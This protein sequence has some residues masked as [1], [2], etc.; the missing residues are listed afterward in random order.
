MK[1]TL[2][3]SAGFCFGVRRAVEL[4]EKIADSGAPYVMLG[5]VIHNDHVI[6]DLAGRGVGCV[7]SLEQVP[8][9]CGVIIRSH[10]EGKEV[11]DQLA[12]MGCP[13]ADATCVKVAK[14][15]QIVADAS[16]RGRQVVII[17]ARNIPR[18]RPL[19]AGVF[20]RKSSEMREN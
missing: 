7:D 20:V 3:K 1:V 8:P 10:G 16:N 11:Y 17:A 2:A 18:Y 9:G 5:P 4:A 19:P 14:I 12:R 6:A 13:V 15:H